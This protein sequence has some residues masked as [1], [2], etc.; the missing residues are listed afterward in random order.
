[1]KTLFALMMLVS[2]PA[3]AD[4]DPHQLIPQVAERTALEHSRDIQEANLHHDHVVRALTRE[5]FAVWA[6]PSRGDASRWR[7]EIESHIEARRR[8]TEGNNQALSDVRSLVAKAKWLQE[9]PG[10]LSGLQRRRQCFTQSGSALVPCLNEEIRLSNDLIWIN[11]R[12]IE[13]NQG[14]HCRFMNGFCERTNEFSRQIIAREQARITD[15]Q[16]RIA[17]VQGGGDD[18]KKAN[19]VRALD[20]RIA[21]FSGDVR[22]EVGEAREL[23]RRVVQAVREEGGRGGRDLAQCSLSESN[24]CLAEAEEAERAITR[25][26]GFD[27]LVLKL[28]KDASEALVKATETGSG[29]NGGT[30]GSPD[31]RI[32]QGGILEVQAQGEWRGVCD[33]SFDSADAEVACRMMGKQLVRFS[34]GVSGHGKFWLDDLACQGNETSLFNCGFRGLGNHDCSSNEHVAVECR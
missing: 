4:H 24:P 23:Q 27:S 18:P 16:A 8:E 32:G 21:D 20:A 29:G 3:L 12:S 15:L 9:A 6:L 13:M 11:Q 5:L 1:M 31:V 28:L 26:A 2:S 19:E 10:R 33:D 30:G 34:T 22:K 17:I 14:R 25:G 7:G